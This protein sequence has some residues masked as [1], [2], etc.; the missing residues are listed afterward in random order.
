MYTV[1]LLV[2]LIIYINSDEIVSSLYDFEPPAFFKK[3]CKNV[4]A[5]IESHPSKAVCL[6]E[7]EACMNSYSRSNDADWNELVIA[8]Q[9]SIYV[10][11]YIFST[12]LLQY[13]LSLNV[14]VLFQ[15]VELN[16]LLTAEKQKHANT[17][18]KLS[19]MIAQVQY[20][21]RRFPIVLCFAG[22]TLYGTVILSCCR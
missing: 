8:E 16:A 17:S 2:F 13:P 21:I 6:T 10:V 4:M 20:I 22:C 12:L 5:A 11:M 1:R 18:F 14:Y 9:T 3:A 15:N 19:E 7:I